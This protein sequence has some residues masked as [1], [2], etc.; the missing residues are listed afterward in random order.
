MIGGALFIYK[1]NVTAVYRNWEGNPNF[2]TWWC[3]V[4]L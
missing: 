1:E 4:N 3:L 2:L